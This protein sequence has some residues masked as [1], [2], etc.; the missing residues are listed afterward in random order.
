[1]PQSSC[2]LLAKK[3]GFYEIPSVQGT[4]TKGGIRIDE[5]INNAVGKNC[6]TDADNNCINV[7]VCDLPF[8][9]NAPSQKCEK[10]EG[11]WFKSA[12]PQQSVISNRGDI[13]YENGK[14]RERWGTDVGAWIYLS[15]AENQQS[16]ISG[17]GHIEYENGRLRERWGT[18][19]GAWIDLSN[20]AFQRTVI[21]SR[22]DKEYED[23]KLREAWN[24]TRG[25]WITLCEQSMV[26]NP[27]CSNGRYDPATRKCL[28]GSNP[29]WRCHTVVSQD[30]QCPKGSTLD[31]FSGKCVGDKRCVLSK[32]DGQRRDFMASS[33]AIKK[34]NEQKNEYICS[35]LV[36]AG[37]HSC[38]Y[39]ECPDGSDANMIAQG[40]E[41]P[42][43]NEC[44]DTV[45]DAN[46]PYYHWCSQKAPCPVEQ[47]GV[48]QNE[49]GCMHLECVDG[50]YDSKT[51]KCYQWKCPDG[52]TEEGAKCVK[53]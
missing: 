49:S 32:E 20:S 23:G 48:V 3:Y 6:N 16:S 4:P 33:F 17:R 52:Y 24:S 36:C 19:A 15:S 5:L 21:S 47:P 38:Q 25:D 13:E 28:N 45:C 27:S 43:P 29:I 11:G 37:D 22:G 7:N 10:T 12:V 44:I 18:D 31:R 51:G 42:K 14:L 53:K 26:L 50:N 8:Y 34:T 41:Y 2:T 1:M 39:N 30:P 46:L 9:W 35:P 40:Y